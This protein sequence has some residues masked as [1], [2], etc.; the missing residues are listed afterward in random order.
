MEREFDQPVEPV[1]TLYPTVEKPDAADIQPAEPVKE[2]EEPQ[3]V[4]SPKEQ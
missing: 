4:L 3:V 1:L 2:K